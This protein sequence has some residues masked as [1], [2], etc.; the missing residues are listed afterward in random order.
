MDF[1]ASDLEHLGDLV[2]TVSGEC[3]LDLLGVR[4]AIWTRVQP[5]HD[6]WFPRLSHRHIAVGMCPQHQDEHAD[7][8]KSDGPP[9]D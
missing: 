4:L 5:S 1:G 9:D 8:S 2:E 3:D 6:D 7:Q